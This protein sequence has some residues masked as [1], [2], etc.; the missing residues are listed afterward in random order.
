MTVKS[1]C[2]LNCVSCRRASNEPCDRVTNP[3]NSLV[4]FGLSGRTG[5]AATDFFRI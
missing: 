1:N 3:A 5:G 4:H 2:R